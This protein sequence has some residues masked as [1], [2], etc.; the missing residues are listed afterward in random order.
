M[1]T[2]FPAAEL[3]REVLMTHEEARLTSTARPWVFFGLGN[4]LISEEEA[5][6][7]PYPTHCRCVCY[8][9]FQVL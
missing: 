6:A 5:G 2:R 9:R 7:D 4:T 1:L 3:Q 8:V